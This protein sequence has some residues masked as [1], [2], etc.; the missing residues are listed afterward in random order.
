MPLLILTIVYLVEPKLQLDVSR[1]SCTEV[2]ANVSRDNG[3][4]TVVSDSEAL[5]CRQGELSLLNCTSGVKLGKTNLENQPNKL[6]AYKLLEGGVSVIHI[7]ASTNAGEQS[8]LNRLSYCRY[9]YSSPDFPAGFVCSS[10]DPPTDFVASVSISI[11]NQVLVYAT[12]IDSNGD[13]ESYNVKNGYPE[14]SALPQ[15]C[16]CNSSKC[17]APVDQPKGQVIVQCDNGDSYLY[18][19]YNNDFIVVSPGTKLAATSNYRDMVLAAQ[20]N[21]GLYQ[22]IVVQSNKVTDVH[23]A[24]ALPLEGSL[25]YSADPITITDVVI[26][27]NETSELEV[28]YM[29]RNDMILYFEVDELGIHPTIQYLSPPPSTTWVAIRVNYDGS[30]VV[31]E[32]SYSNGTSI[33]RTIKA[34]LVQSE[35]ETVGN[36]TEGSTPSSSTTVSQTNSTES[37]QPCTCVTEEPTPTSNVTNDSVNSTSTSDH[38][39]PTYIYILC[40]VLLASLCLCLGLFVALMVMYCRLKRLGKYDI[41]RDRK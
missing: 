36:N 31:A 37:F 14:G 32:A 5:V 35:N 21:K 29:L 15:N 30:S 34:G 8:S 4:F 38:C 20:R 18:E 26:S 11:H 24:S 28:C 41:R 25:A 27:V 17:L 10:Y 39:D 33:L 7:A 40:A 22:D 13:L 16:T 2:V 19:I 6:T 23:G 9:F 3:T 12:Y 1:H